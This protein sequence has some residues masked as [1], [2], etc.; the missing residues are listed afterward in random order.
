MNNKTP[1]DVL[2]KIDESILILENKKI[3]FANTNTLKLFETT[4]SELINTDFLLFVSEEYTNKISKKIDEIVEKKEIFYNE[5]AKLLVS[6]RKIIETKISLKPNEQ[7]NQ[8]IFVQIKSAKNYSETQNEAN[9][10]M[11]SN[12]KLCSYTDEGI[13]L[14]KQN[15]DKNHIFSWIIENINDGALKILNKT[16]KEVVNLPLNKL[17]IP[18]FN[19]KLPD[20]I[21]N[22]FTESLEVYI[23]N[24]NEY[25]KVD[26]IGLSAN[27]CILKLSDVSELTNVRNEINRYLQR[28][29]LLTELLSISNYSETYTQKFQ[30]ILERTAYHFSP[31]RILIIKDNL[32][33]EEGI[34]LDQWANEDTKLF[35][36]DFFIPYKQIPSWNEMLTKRKMILGFSIRNLPKDLQL[37]LENHDMKNIYTFAIGESGAKKPYGSIIFENKETKEWDNT[38]INY[39]KM[40]S[41]LISGLIT[42]Q[43]NEKK[44]IEAKNHAEEAD[45]LKSAFLANMSHDI[46]IP[47]TSIIGFSDLLADEELSVGERE[48]FIELITKSGRDLLNLIDNVIDMAKIETNQINIQKNDCNL[49]HLFKDLHNTHS[50][51]LK[52]IEHDDINLIVDLPEKFRDISFQTDIFRIK[53]VFDNLIDNAIKY[54]DKGEIR[55]GIS[56]L[57]DSEIEFYVFDT[58]IGMEEKTQELIFESFK[59]VD[60]SYTKEFT[61]VGLGLAITKSLI[62]LLG[63]TIRVNS[64]IGKGSTFYFTQVAKLNFRKVKE[65]KKINLP[66]DIDWKDKTI[67]ICEDVEENFRFLQFVLATKKANILWYKNGIDVVNHIV[68][69]KPADLILMDIKMPKLDGLSATRKIKEISTVPIIIQTSYNMNEEKELAFQA[70][71][72]DCIIKPINVEKLLKIISKVFAD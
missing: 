8:G 4:L 53:Q 50:R 27:K 65:K 5:D 32:N 18:D 45:K 35:S 59:K 68:Q 42:N 39:L 13:F 16:K 71:C 1:Y 44:L 60:Q 55:F 2:N 70:G 61:G 31:K 29:E 25:F 23:L 21:D 30:K 72:A 49:N 6:Q 63:G 67:I 7:L 12:E 46:R 57:T 33:T 51:N 41:V 26:I 22:A 69:K 11:L 48:E 14:L 15:D 20:R 62:E 36:N 52:I 38:E 40:I 47:M 10:D 24:F 3:V 19:Y 17:L 34:I 43:I 58:G 64:E 56:N 54:T 28:N 9:T 66:D 37:F